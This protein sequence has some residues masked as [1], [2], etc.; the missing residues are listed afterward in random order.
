MYHFPKG[1]VGI[2]INRVRCEYS[3]FVVALHGERSISMVIKSPVTFAE[4]PSPE[5]YEIDIFMGR[6]TD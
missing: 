6:V 5:I 1:S 4:N 2:Q 3:S